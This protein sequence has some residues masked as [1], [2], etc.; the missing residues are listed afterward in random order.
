M[1][2]FFKFV[3]TLVIFLSPILLVSS[4]E[5]YPSIKDFYV[6]VFVPTPLAE[7]YFLL[8]SGCRVYLVK[9]PTVSR[10]GCIW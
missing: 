1:V 5:V 8:F 10:R 2:K 7:P 9:Q 4:E 3:N 6:F